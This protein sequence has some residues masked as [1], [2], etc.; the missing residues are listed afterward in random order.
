M[1]ESQISVT[2]ILARHFRHHAKF[3]QATMYIHTY[4]HKCTTV[5]SESIDIHVLRGL[6][7]EIPAVFHHHAIQLLFS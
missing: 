6:T 4:V 7:L 5:P 3:L 1:L 2:H